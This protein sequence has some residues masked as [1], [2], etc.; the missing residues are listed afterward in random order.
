MRDETG[1]HPLVDSLWGDVEQVCYVIH[2]EKGAVG[3]SVAATGIVSV[4][5]WYYA[6]CCALCGGINEK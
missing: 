4:C 3:A 6:G 2:I 5:D 1:T